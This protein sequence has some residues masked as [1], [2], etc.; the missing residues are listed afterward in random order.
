M[1]K[2]H[3]TMNLCFFC[4]EPAS[5]LLDT[6]VAA[7]RPNAK[8]GFDDSK[9]VYFVEVCPDCEKLM[10]Q[11]IILISV[12]D[13]ESEK[14]AMDYELAQAEYAR[15]ESKNGRSWSQQHPFRYIP[16][17]YRTGGWCVVTE[18]GM[19]NMMNPGKALAH[20]LER[21]WSLVE[22]SVWDAIGLPRKE[23]GDD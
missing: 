4:L 19:R 7:W 16:N 8:V 23:V 13:G 12:K 20:I 5:I 18:E 6:R 21:R 15:L 10:E 22:D 1:S 9:A 14:V 2:S 11:G 3:V 17:P